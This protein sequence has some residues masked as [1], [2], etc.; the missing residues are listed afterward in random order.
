MSS[1][2]WVK[3]SAGKKSCWFY[4]EM[5]THRYLPVQY[6]RVNKRRGKGKGWYL[7]IRNEDF[8]GYTWYPQ[9]FPKFNDAKNVGQLIVA[10]TFGVTSK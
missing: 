4:T 10:S 9:A 1:A 8:N 3:N 2:E 5:P 7:H 6:A